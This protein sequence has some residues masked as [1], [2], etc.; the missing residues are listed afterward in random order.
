ML[1]ASQPELLEWLLNALWL[2]LVVAIAAMCYSHR[3]ARSV[4]LKR[5][6]ALLAL[7]CVAAIIFPA[8][9]VSD[10]LHS[11]QWAVEATSRTA[12]KLKHTTQSPC[13]THLT[14][15]TISLASFPRPSSRTIAVV[16]PHYSRRP[17]Q[18]SLSPAAARAPPPRPY[19][20]SL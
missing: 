19:F 1:A 17:H 16:R 2:L 5:P 4:S 20:T 7:T 3:R 8:I 13:S 6:A 15:A 14:V 11:E 18:V 10:D 12:K 9:S